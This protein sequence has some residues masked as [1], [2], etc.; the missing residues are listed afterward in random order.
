MSENRPFSQRFLTVIG[1][2]GIAAIFLPFVRGI[3]S[4]AASPLAVALNETALWRLAIPFLLPI[5]ISGMFIRRNFSGSL[6]LLEQVFAYLAG[7]SAA[8]ATLSM[9]LIV[10]FNVHGR[11][12]DVDYLL[13]YA[14]VSP[15]IILAIGGYLVIRNCRIGKLRDL[16]AVMAMQ[17]AYIGNCAPCLFLSFG[18]W[19]I[20]AYCAI[21][22]VVV[23]FFQIGLISGE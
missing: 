19:D 11:S 7:I 18:G 3:F 22:T 14:M 10:G 6:S 1:M 13:L 15:V 5:V 17:V 23:Y 16:S 21:L 4:P 9:Y 2:A 20:G 12:S 8:C